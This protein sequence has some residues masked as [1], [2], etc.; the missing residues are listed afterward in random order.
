MVDGWNSNQQQGP[1]PA[2]SASS[3]ELAPTPK[4][5]H[6]GLGIASFSLFGS[7]AVLFLVLLAAFIAELTEVVDFNNPDLM[8]SGEIPASIQSLPLL[9]GLIFLLFLTLIGNLAGLGF[10]IA[11][12]LQ[13][14][15]KKL[16]AVLG[17][18]LNG[19][20]I[21]FLFVVLLIGALIGSAA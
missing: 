16:F 10:G 7:M 21:G 5:K 20:V 14:R 11:G 3:P 12:L 9:A 17:T 2:S 1:E 19:I 18:V 4:Q 13:K 6:S 15:R 8:D